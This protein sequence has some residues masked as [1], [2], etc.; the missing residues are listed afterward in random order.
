MLQYVFVEEVNDP[1]HVKLQMSVTKE[2]IYPCEMSR[3]SKTV[4]IESRLKDAWD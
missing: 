3:I 1:H 4:G 2:Q